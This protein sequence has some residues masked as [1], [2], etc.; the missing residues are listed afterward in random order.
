VPQELEGSPLRNDANL[1][2]YWRFEDNALDETTNNND[3][4]LSGSPAY[5]TGKFGKG[6][7]LEYSSS[8]YASI[9]DA[10][11]TGLDLASDFTFEAWIKPEQLA[12]TLGAAMMIVAKDG[13][14]PANT[15]SYSFY[16]NS[17][18]TLFC[19]YFDSAGNRT[20][21]D[22]DSGVIDTAGI[23]YHVAVTCDISAHEMVFYV[24]GSS[25][26][27]G[28]TTV[29]ATSINNSA[30]AFDVGARAYVTAPRY[31]DGV[32][33]EVAVF[34]RVLTATEISNLYNSNIKK[35]MGVDNK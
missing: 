1:V 10:L 26:A 22:S 27:S 28:G 18:N 5:T 29:S 7:D 14:S 33:D 19:D 23:W 21:K 30:T 6:L 3:L 13:V 32:I 34:S 25:V 15:R 8:Q 31:F 16:V 2:G 35:Y 17:D 4:T 24:N 11:Q 12:S 9:T 20:A